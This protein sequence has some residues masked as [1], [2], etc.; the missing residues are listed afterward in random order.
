MRSMLVVLFQS[1]ARLLYHTHQPTTALHRHRPLAPLLQRP[2]DQT[3]LLIIVLTRLLFLVVFPLLLLTLLVA[4][5]ALELVFPELVDG[6]AVDVGED[7]FEDVR[8]PCYGLA[9]DAFFD[10]LVG[11]SFCACREG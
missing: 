3:R 8:V 9:F 11:V 10:V 6:V 4:L 7:D 1:T 2:I 5:F